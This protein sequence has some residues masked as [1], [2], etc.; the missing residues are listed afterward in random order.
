MLMVIK[1]NLISAGKKQRKG[2]RKL[3]ICKKQTKRKNN[4][5]I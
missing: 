4:K 3:K 5:K 2:K 1:T